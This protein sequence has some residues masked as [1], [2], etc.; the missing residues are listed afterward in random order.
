MTHSTD[1]VAAGH[2]RLPLPSSEVH[3][4]VE[5]TQA[6][7][8]PCTLPLWTSAKAFDSVNHE[9]LQ[10]LSEA[11]GI[12]PNSSRASTTMATWCRSQVTGH[13]PQLIKG[14]YYDGNWVRLAGLGV[15]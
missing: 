15:K 1:S 6:H 14:L 4:L 10:A 13:P 3:R 8:H 12:H 9:A 7:V 5:L 2:P 11:R